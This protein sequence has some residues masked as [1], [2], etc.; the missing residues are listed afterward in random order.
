MR[1]TMY[2]AS[3][4]VLVRMLGNLDRLLEK[5]ELHAQS[6]K[7]AADVFL[8]AR[9]YP[10]MFPLVRQVQI[11]TDMAKGCVARL[12]GQEPPR[13]EDSEATL[14]ELRTRVAKTIDYIK[15][16]NAAQIDASEDRTITLKIGGTTM[17]FEGLP[18]LLHFV[19]PNFYFHV[20][21]AYAIFRHWGVEIGKQDFLG[22]A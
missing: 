3:V 22:T 6:K 5:A 8:N 20:T 2:S 14:P 12:A 4:P 9:L 1:I 19:L 16:Y 21:T 10:D 13:Y 18:Y 15:S 7:F 11:A 17:T